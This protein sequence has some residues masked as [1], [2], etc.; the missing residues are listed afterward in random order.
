MDQTKNIKIVTGWYLATLILSVVVAL[1]LETRL[2]EPLVQYLDSEIERDFTIIESV[3]LLLS[4]PL[5]LMHLVAL[6]GLVRERGYAKGWF[7]VSSIGLFILSPF[8]GPTIDHAVA[9]T[10]ASV[11][12]VLMG[13]LIALLV[14]TRSA[15][16][17]S[18]FGTA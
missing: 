17:K 15:F 12:L 7:F 2:P 4:L 9:A 10:I 11:N 3:V 13:V 8:M 18:G 1:Y 5:L 16:N 14:F 6:F